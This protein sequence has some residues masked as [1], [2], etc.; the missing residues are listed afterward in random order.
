MGLWDPFQ[1]AFPWLVNG[2]DPN[3]LLSG[4]ILQVDTTRLDHKVSKIR[5]SPSYQATQSYYLQT[6][7]TTTKKKLKQTQ[8]TEKKQS[9]HPPKKQPPSQSFISPHDSLAKKTTWE[10]SL[11]QTKLNLGKAVLTELKD[12]IYNV[13]VVFS[14]QDLGV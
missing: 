3:S 10:V 14:T 2:G 12:Q 7:T 11:L 5:A 4:V 13:P 9:H 6:S 8:T 1:T